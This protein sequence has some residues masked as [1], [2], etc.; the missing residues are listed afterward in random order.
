MIARDSHGYSIKKHSHGKNTPKELRRLENVSV[1][2]QGAG[3]HNSR[4]S[5]HEEN[6][7]EG[8]EKC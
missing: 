8:S 2:T 5:Y 3:V 6:N 7:K 4:F 1:V